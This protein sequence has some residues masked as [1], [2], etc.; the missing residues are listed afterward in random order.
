MTTGA[1]SVTILIR[2]TPWQTIFLKL[3]LKKHFKKWWI[4][5]IIN[6]VSCI[7]DLFHW[8]YNFFSRGISHVGI[9]Q[10]LHDAG[11]FLFCFAI[12]YSLCIPPLISFWQSGTSQL[13]KEIRFCRYLFSYRYTVWHHNM[14]RTKSGTR[15]AEASVSLFCSSHIMTLYCVSITEQTDNGKILSICFI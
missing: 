12:L 14:G 10:A 15:A 5:F 4:N 8:S 7:V 1:N 11:S 2:T 9:I 6:R 13:N 3:A